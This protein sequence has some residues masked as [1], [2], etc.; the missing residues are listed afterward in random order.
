MSQNDTDLF[1]ASEIFRQA[2]GV[3]DSAFALLVGKIEL[4][5]PEIL[6]VPQ[7]AQ[8][9]A[10]AAPA[11]HDQD[12]VYPGIHKRLQRIVDHGLVVDRQNMLV[13]YSVQRMKPRAGSASQDNTFH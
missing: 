13:R 12:V 5:E 1:P 8:E 9:I 7:Q 6:A 11:G 10:C 2:Q 4:L 3:R